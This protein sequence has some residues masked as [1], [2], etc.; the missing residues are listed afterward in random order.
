SLLWRASGPQIRM[1]LE[2]TMF[3]GRR[4]SH[5]KSFW[6]S[7]MGCGLVF[8]SIGAGRPR[9]SR[10]K[11]VVIRLGILAAVV[12]GRAWVCSLSRV[13]D[14]G[15]VWVGSFLAGLP[16]SSEFDDLVAQRR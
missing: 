2:L 11:M 1:S 16:R 10:S 3:P 4:W 7:S 13:G 8:S 14:Q 5:S 12:V 15:R 6:A 9:F